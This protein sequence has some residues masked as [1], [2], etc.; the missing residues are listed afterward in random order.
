MNKLFVIFIIS[1]ACLKSICQ[2]A[3][4]VFKNNVQATGTIYVST[5]QGTFQGSG[6]FVSS[7]YFITNYHV[8]KNIISGYI[9]VN[10]SDIK[11]NL[12][13]IIKIDAIH[14]LA[15]LKINGTHCCKIY[16]SSTD[17]DIGQK[18]F[19]IGS[20]RGLEASI[21][22]GIVSAIRIIGPNDKLIQ[23]SAAIAH[24]S[25]GGPIFD[26]NGKV[27]AIAV[28][29]LEAS[30]AQ[31][32]NFAIPSTYLIQD[33]S[34][35]IALDS[36]DIVDPNTIK[37]DEL[38]K[39]AEENEY[40]ELMENVLNSKTYQ[41]PFKYYTYFYDLGANYFNSAAQNNNKQNFYKALQMFKNSYQIGRYIY[42][43]KWGL[44]EL[45]TQLVLTMGKAALNAGKKA[46]TATYFKKLADANI[47]GTVND[48]TSYQLPYQWLSYYYKE[49]KDDANFIKYSSMG[50][51]F[52]PK[53]DY[54]DAVMLDYYRDKKD[55]DALF[56]K[57]DEII[58]A[59][60][61]SVQYHSNYANEAFIYV[62][63][64]DAGTTINNRETLLK[65]VGTEL[66]KVL[67]KRPNDVNTNWLLGQ[68]YFNAAI[69]LKEQAN[70]RGA[71][72]NTKV[73]DVFS[74]AIPYADKAL[75]ILEESNKKSDKSKYKSI[76][77]LMQRIYASLN[78]PHK[79]KA[80][81][82]KYDSAEAKF[83]N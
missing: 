42:A 17:V 23:I 63:N 70:A 47:T 29:G 10:Q 36:K 51:I 38:P 64:S 73:K 48:K 72:F 21:T 39:H 54:Y 37:K 8:I 4:S 31:S 71:N 55:Y 12:L 26:E 49:N 45:D 9:K 81:Q 65:N 53:D 69:D 82:A 28:S 60:P 11:Y 27:I 13:E 77:N 59:Y 15:I 3:R 43:N 35:L 18:I 32:T 83:V 79:V 5:N 16:L 2:D 74:K 25:S 41:V 46:E 14:D 40:A 44:S 56:K 78:Q 6:F 62:Y 57:Y 19:A 76:V 66:Q 58:T 34:S 22:E 1:F 75:S 33:L 67:T 30:Y 7:E 80:Y 24:G 68:Y 52:F 61:D 20:P 50:K